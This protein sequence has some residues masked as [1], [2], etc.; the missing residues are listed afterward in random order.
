MVG[1]IFPVM[2]RCP[3]P[4]LCR[5]NSVARSVQLWCSWGVK[6]G[7]RSSCLHFLF[8]D[9]GANTAWGNAKCP[10]RGHHSLGSIS[11]TDRQGC[12]GELQGGILTN[13]KQHQYKWVPRFVLSV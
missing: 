10:S 2:H 1:V 8:P 11:D 13:K 3:L 12:E 6:G 4:F 5:D 9:S 7:L